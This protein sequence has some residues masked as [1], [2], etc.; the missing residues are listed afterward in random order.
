[1]EKDPE[2]RH[3]VNVEHAMR[4]RIGDYW[5]EMFVPILVVVGRLESDDVLVCKTKKDV[6]GN[7]WE[8]DL[9]KLEVWDIN[10]FWCDCSP[11]SM[12]WARAEAMKVMFG[13]DVGK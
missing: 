13:D 2:K 10:K 5:H 4:P 7:R 8:W 3:K 9:T 1:M 6:G 11:E 12:V